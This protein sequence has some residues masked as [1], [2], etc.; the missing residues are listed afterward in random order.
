MNGYDLFDYLEDR[1]KQV[2]ECVKDNSDTYA[3]FSCPKEYEKEVR[4]ELERLNIGISLVSSIDTESEKVEYVILK[5]RQEQVDNIV[6]DII[7]RG[8]KDLHNDYAYNIS[9]SKFTKPAEISLCF[10]ILSIIFIW[11]C[12]LLGIIFAII[13]IIFGCLQKKDYRGKKPG[14]AI[15]GIVLSI[16][17]LTGVTILLILIAIL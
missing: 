17:S 8:K 4:E 16:I 9:D 10:G 11:C 6:N 2:R 7:S 3:I 13:G 14:M 1:E 12:G 15:A 5:E